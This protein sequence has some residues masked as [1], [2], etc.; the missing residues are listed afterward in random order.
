MSV[1]PELDA[2]LDE[3][4]EA[5]RDSP[6]VGAMIAAMEWVRRV[7]QQMWDESVR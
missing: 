6:T 7:L 2:E 1:R 4:I 5:L 3:A